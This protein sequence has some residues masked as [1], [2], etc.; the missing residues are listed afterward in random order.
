MEQLSIPSFITVTLFCI[1]LLN[2]TEA[3]NSRMP[4]SQA[5]TFS[6][7]AT[8]LPKANGSNS[9]RYKSGL[10]ENEDIEAYVAAVSTA[11]STNSDIPSKWDLPRRSPSADDAMREQLLWDVEMFLGRIAMIAG[12]ILLAD[13]VF[14][15]QSMAEQVTSFLQ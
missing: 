13:E 4:V 7:P 6:S 1:M 2:P 8:A 12:L 10:A 11:V 9:L 3:W 14:T 5:R 15:G